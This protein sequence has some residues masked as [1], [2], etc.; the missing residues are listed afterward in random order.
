MSADFDVV[1]IADGGHEIT[2]PK[3]VR[4]MVGCQSIRLS[5]AGFERT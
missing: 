3:S 4:L 5:L 2:F 1:R